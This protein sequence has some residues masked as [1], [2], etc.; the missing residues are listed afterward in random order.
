MVL[1]TMSA[2][3]YATMSIA[4]ACKV[5]VQRYVRYTLLLEPLARPV[6]YKDETDGKTKD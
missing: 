3:C 4:L 2:F 6:K 5:S 1:L